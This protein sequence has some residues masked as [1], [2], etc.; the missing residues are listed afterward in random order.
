MNDEQIRKTALVMALI[1]IAGLYAVSFIIGPQ[2]FAI[3]DIGT[4]DVGKQVVVQGVIVSG[5]VSEGNIFLEIGDQTG[6]ID[7]VMFERTARGKTINIGEG[8]EV[9]V[10]GQINFYK[11]GLEIIATTIA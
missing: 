3:G 1:G 8:I 4:D 5:R 9:E 11:G 2:D 6:S 7:I 10:T